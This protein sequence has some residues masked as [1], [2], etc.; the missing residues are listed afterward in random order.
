MSCYF[1]STRD[2]PEPTGDEPDDADFADPKIYEPVCST[3][4]FLICFFFNDI[5]SL[6][7]SSLALADILHNVLLN[8]SY[9]CAS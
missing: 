8:Y 2:A 5:V 4:I 3:F 9:L 7:I 1:S 6:F